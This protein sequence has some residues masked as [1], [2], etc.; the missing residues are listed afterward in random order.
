[1]LA[2]L[3]GRA[4]SPGYMDIQIPVADRLIDPSRAATASI[5]NMTF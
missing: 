5:T 4:A 1:M 3:S 2:G